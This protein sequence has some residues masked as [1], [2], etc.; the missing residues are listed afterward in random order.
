[1]H[2]RPVVILV[3]ARQVALNK[4]NQVVIEMLKTVVHQMAL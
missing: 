3:N 2:Y 1:M 4:Y